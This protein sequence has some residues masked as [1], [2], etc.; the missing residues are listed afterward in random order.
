MAD[1]VVRGAATGAFGLE[2]RTLNALTH[3]LT[4]ARVLR[5]EGAAF[6]RVLGRLVLEHDPRTVMEQ[7]LVRRI[8]R[9]IVRL[10]RAALVD[11]VTFANCFSE[12]PESGRDELNPVALEGLIATV[13]RYEL[14][15]GRALAKAHHELERLESRR[16]PGAA[17]V[18]PVIVDFNW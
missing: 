18:P 10:E 12:D 11:A 3:G 8:A 15:I 5:E 9:M 6:D 4:S 17:S 1:D 16:E 13:N 7:A 14:A 2:P